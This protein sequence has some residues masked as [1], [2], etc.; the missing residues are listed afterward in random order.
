LN[1]KKIIAFLT[2]IA[3]FTMMLTTFATLVKPVKAA[4][5]VTI[6]N[7]QG[8]L[9]FTGYYVVYGE[10]KNTGDT[11]AKNIYVKI[12]YSSTEG[13]DEDETETVIN[14]LLPGRKAPFAGN[15]AV[16]GSLVKSYT[17]ELL[18]LTM[19]TEDL[20]KVLDIVSSSTEVNIIQNMMV[21]GTV[22]NSGTQTATYTR[23]YAT[24][25]DGPSGTGN[26]VAVTGATAQPTN[27]DPGQ[28]GNFQMGFFVTPGKTYAS[29]VLAAESDQYA[30][31]T[32]YTAATGQTSSTTP[33]SSTSLSPSPTIPEFPPF[34]VV[35]L[36][37]VAM[38]IVA[39]ALKRKQL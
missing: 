35:P 7:H 24:F 38:L 15:A 2:C 32:E 29:Y 10:V 21:T 14:V 16:Q 6:V 17:V 18:D 34:I 9:D 8:F 37:I 25:Y 3:V 12:T 22:K 20:P 11:A 27:L 26:V 23:V 13:L 1:T 28:T 39:V 4:E 33:S 31:T 36:L 19:P 30:A 5:Q